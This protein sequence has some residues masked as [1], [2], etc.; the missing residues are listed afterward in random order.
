MKRIFIVVA[1]AF[2]FHSVQA[3]DD[4]EEYKVVLPAD[5]QKCIL[6]ASPDRIPD[7]A[8][9]DQ[10]KEAKAQIADFQ[11]TV[12]V[13]RECLH[14]AEDNPGNTEGNKQAIISSF[15]Y[16]VDMEERIAERFNLAIRSYKKRNA[17]Q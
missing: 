15:N 9:Y 14:E 6:P 11:A 10:L 4:A 17:S 7:D 2:L 3:Q 8:S 13:F 12:V 1:A 5:A 16:S